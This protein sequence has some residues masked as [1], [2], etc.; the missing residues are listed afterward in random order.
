MLDSLEW[1]S[2]SCN[3][4]SNLSKKKLNKNSYCITTQNIHESKENLY[5]YL[6]IP[7]QQGVSK[8][9]QEYP[10]APKRHIP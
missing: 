2:L 1:G 8:S 4:L 6:Q 3:R 7:L 9:S 5:V 10:H